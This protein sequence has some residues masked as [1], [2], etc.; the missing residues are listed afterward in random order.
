MF[1]IIEDESVEF[2][3]LTWKKGKGYQQSTRLI[4]HAPGVGRMLVDFFGGEWWWQV[5]FDFFTSYAIDNSISGFA[6]TQEQAMQ[7]CLGAKSVF[8]SEISRLAGEFLG[9]EF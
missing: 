7:N 1:E 2:G 5:R 8:L 6:E 4:A 3:G 9:S